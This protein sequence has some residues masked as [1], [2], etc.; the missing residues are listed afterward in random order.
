MLKETASS[1][2]IRDFGIAPKIRGLADEIETLAV[3]EVEILGLAIS[4]ELEFIH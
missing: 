4:Q 2:L 3:D 1:S